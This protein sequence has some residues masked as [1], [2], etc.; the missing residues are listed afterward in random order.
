M[1]RPVRGRHFDTV[2]SAGGGCAL[3]DGLAPCTAY[4]L[5]MR[6]VTLESGPGPLSGPR[7]HF[8]TQPQVGAHAPRAQPLYKP[9]RARR[10]GTRSSR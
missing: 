5:V 3:L 9:G 8:T 2:A 7:L 6:S 10:R 4:S 1:P